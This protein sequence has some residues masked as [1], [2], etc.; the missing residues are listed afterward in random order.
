ML[1]A[2]LYVIYQGCIWR[3]LRRKFGNWHTICVRLNRWAE[4]GVLQQVA[5][6]L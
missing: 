3:G 6:E 1:D 5:A 2:W 4:V